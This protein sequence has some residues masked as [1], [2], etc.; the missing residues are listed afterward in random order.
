MK[1]L[2]RPGSSENLLTWNTYIPGFIRFEYNLLSKT[3]QEK[4]KTC[5]I[6]KNLFSN[7]TE[8]I[9]GKYNSQTLWLL[10]RFMI[11]KPRQLY[12]ILLN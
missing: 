6:L 8:Q 10:K 1:L 11:T 5:V 3:R 4:H 12:T 7:F 9:K 2:F